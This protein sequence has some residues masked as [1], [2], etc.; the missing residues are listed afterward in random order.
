MS[1]LACEFW[2][3]QKAT[4]IDYGRS[5]AKLVEANSIKKRFYAVVLAIPV[6]LQPANKGPQAH[7]P[8]L[9]A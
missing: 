2:F 9:Y 3:V 1:I 8:A 7:I 5:H 4:K 6:K